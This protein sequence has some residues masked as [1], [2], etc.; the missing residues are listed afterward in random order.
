MSSAL[1]AV[2]ALNAA[3]RASPNDPELAS[4]LVR[5][6]LAANVLLCA[7]HAVRTLLRYA[8]ESHPRVCDMLASA[9][10]FGAFGASLSWCPRGEACDRPVTN[11]TAD[12]A[13]A[14]GSAVGIDDGQLWRGERGRVGR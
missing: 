4:E 7:A 12:S 13:I 5:A 9:R 14:P 10:A 1:D 11:S 3:M 6:C 2:D 8:E